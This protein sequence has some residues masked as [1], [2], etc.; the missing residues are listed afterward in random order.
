ME[1]LVAQLP[2]GKLVKLGILDLVDLG[3]LDMVRVR[4]HSTMSQ[5]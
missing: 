2:R 1:G 4:R 3:D 5:Q